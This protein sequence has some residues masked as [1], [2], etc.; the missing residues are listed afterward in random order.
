MAENSTVV[1]TVFT[2]VDQA[3]AKVEKLASNFSELQAQA[4]SAK[5]EVAKAATLPGGTTAAAATPMA[6]AAKAAPPRGGAALGEFSAEKVAMFREEQRLEKTRQRMASDAADKFSTAGRISLG[7]AQV[8]G[9]SMTGISGKM[10]Q[11][12][13]VLGPI[14]IDLAQFGGRVGAL[15]GL[16]AKMGPLATAA[17]VALSGFSTALDSMRE[18]GIWGMHTDA[19][20]T[21]KSNAK[22]AKSLGYRD[23]AEMVAVRATGKSMEQQ[24]KLTVAAKKYAAGLGSLPADA[25]A[26]EMT[27]YNKRLRDTGLKVLREAGLPAS[28]MGDVMREVTD[29]A[30]AGLP[31]QQ[32]AMQEKMESEL[33]V[34][35]AMK[36]QASFVGTLPINATRAEM[37]AFNARLLRAGTDMLASGELFGMSLEEILNTLRGQASDSLAATSAA[38]RARSAQDIKTGT[39]VEEA[40]KEFNKRKLGKGEDAKLAYDA[41]L[42]SEAER[43]YAAQKLTDPRELQGIYADLRSKTKLD[44][45]KTSFDF[46]NSKFDIKQNFAEGIEPGDVSVAFTNDIAALAE[47]QMTSGFSPIFGGI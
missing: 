20:E 1:E 43:I 12:G 24:V 23:A 10:V 19:Y 30:K 15:G 32:L 18:E 3:S 13:G 21:H 35:A 33:R 17:G 40:A 5:A 2:L 44:K 41:A 34:S 37:E 36:K 45:S 9:G 47:R 31:A 46:R 6:E 8:L 29:Q 22:V 38:M 28:Q 39:A 16:M 11:V 42:H 25:T 7:A 14:G 26:A 27:A 4:M